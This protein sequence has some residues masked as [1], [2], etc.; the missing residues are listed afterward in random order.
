MNEEKL[1]Q[2]LNNIGQTDIP[3]NAALIAE[4]TSQRFTAALNILQAQRPQ[5]TRFVIGL[6]LLAAAAVI[7]F[8][9]A[10]GLSVGQR[11]T[12]PQTRL[13]SLNLTGYASPTPTHPTVQQAKDSFWRQKMLA[14]MQPRPYAR[15]NFDKAGLLNDYKQYLK[16]KYND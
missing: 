11:S 9:F 4:Q 10:I 7:V 16:E 8:A 12:L 14:A 6:R 15:T 5:R 3:P 2:I 13:S 1:K